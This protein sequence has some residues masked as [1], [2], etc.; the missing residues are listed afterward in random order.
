MR[1]DA[2]AELAERLKRLRQDAGLTQA[3]L[4]RALNVS[5]ALISSWESVTNPTVPPLER[6]QSYGDVLRARSVSVEGVAEELAALYERA[7]ARN[8]VA[9]APAEPAVWRYPDGQ[10]V[11]IV[12]AKI[13]ARYREKLLYT[14]PDD[15]D[16]VRSHSYADLDS[17]IELY[18]HLR[19]MNPSI[20]STQRAKNPSHSTS[21]G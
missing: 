18:G 2:A 11:I 4:A 15:P 8:P 21:P 9:V 3:Q 7:A 20:D 1:Q 13:P 16:F 12:C 19:A 17:V 5:P 6:L 14:D 10:D